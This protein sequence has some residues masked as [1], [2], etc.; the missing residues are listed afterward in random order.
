MIEEKWL[1]NV[2]FTTVQS[3]ADVS[4]VKKGTNGDFQASDLSR[5]INTAQTNEITVRAWLARAN[6]RKS[7]LVFC[8]DLEHISGLVDM[9]RRHGVEAHFITGDTPK[10]VRSKKLDEFRRSEFPVLLNCGVFTEGTDIPNIDCVLLARPTKSRNL[11]VQMIGRGMRLHP[12][13]ENCHIIDM[14]ASLET[15]I[16]TTPTL[17][18]LDPSEVLKEVDLEKV[19]ELRERKELEAQREENLSRVA[20]ARTVEPARRNRKITFT[21]Y[22]SVYDLIEDTAGDRH[23]RRLSLLAWVNVAQSRWILSMQGGDYLT[24]DIPVPPENLEEGDGV[25]YRV[26]FTQKLPSGEKFSK[27]P[28]MRPRE[29]ATMPDFEGAI[30]A[31]DTFAMER[32]SYNQL[33]HAQ[34][35]RKQPASPAQLLFLNKIRDMHNQLTGD[36]ITKGKAGDMITKLKF[37]AKQRFK[38]LESTKKMQEKASVRKVQLQEMRNREEVRVGPLAAL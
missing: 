12:G 28:Y 16:V 1:S 24:I 5:A 33:S 30:R 2:I 11:L 6:G 34:A 23:I 7:T 9:F 35:W 20:T 25:V 15:G 18:G 27:S 37:G 19:K 14:V 21:D 4:K 29:I 36:T 17:F 22:D 13:K 31:A 32:Y 10:T 8:A 38:A 3:K 26:R